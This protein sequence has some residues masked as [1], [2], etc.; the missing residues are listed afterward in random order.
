MYVR[1]F[2][3]SQ[4]FTVNP[5]QTVVDVMALMREK[6]IRRVPVVEK[7][8]L[9]GLLTDGDLREISP[10]PATTLS[11]W[12]LNNLIAKITVRDV[13]KKKVVTCPPDMR[14]EDAALL[15]M[16]RKISGLPVVDEGKLVGII[17]L[18]EITRAFLDVMGSRS[19]GERVVIETKD[20][21]GVIS[22]L[23]IATKEH[24][25][26]I[27]SLAVFHREENK[28]QILVHLQ[29]DNAAEVETSLEKK[30]Y[31]IRK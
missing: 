7:G 28:V 12:E 11:V 20:K 23:G 24:D 27:A 15:M 18:V 9:V 8:K 6:R 25:V 21:V 2:M 1:Q 26:N 29:G 4:V 16:D 22:D 10:S 31:R 14:L 5:E 13:A 19:P 30:G 3:I 17:T